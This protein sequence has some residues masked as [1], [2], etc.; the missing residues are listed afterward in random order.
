MRVL[1]F[2]TFDHLHP[3]HTFFL[4]EASKHGEL[5][6]VVAKDA[7]VLRIKGRLAEESQA[8]RMAAL[9]STFPNVRVVLGSDDDF[10]S[11]VRTFQPDLICL[12]YDQELPPGVSMADLPCRTKHLPAFQPE[13]W[14]SSLRRGS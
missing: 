4:E 7:N 5:T 1:V 6:V 13:K 9:Q 12:G 8:E 2:G 10:L 11:P 3:G 14:K